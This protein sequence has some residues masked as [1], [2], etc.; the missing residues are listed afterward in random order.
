MRPA[1][2][3]WVWVPLAAVVFG[4]TAW[5]A[6]APVGSDSREQVFVIPKGTWARRSAG[7][8]LE[9]L[10]SEIRL[11]LGIK[12]ILVMK[13]Q[14]DVPQ[15]F[16]PVLIMPGQSFRLPFG[17]AS[18]NQFACTAHVSGTLTVTVEPAPAPGWD[19]LRWRAGAIVNRNG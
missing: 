4:A 14:D 1:R 15:M 2:R 5:A 17:V 8:K 18:S 7:E 6:F 9:V 13:N 19:R 3:H 12:D 11:T 16:G 10:P